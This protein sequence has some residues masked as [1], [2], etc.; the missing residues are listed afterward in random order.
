MLIKLQAEQVSLFWD[1]IREGLIRSYKIPKE[2]QQEFAIASLKQILVGDTQCWLGYELNE[3]NKLPKY[4]V[5]TQIVD[6]KYLGL[7]SLY[8]VAFYSLIT[9][10]KEMLAE[11]ASEIVPYAKSNN[12]QVVLADFNHDRVKEFLTELGFENYRSTAR[13]FL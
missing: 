7:R 8:I 12:C 4:F 11:F 2:Y 10:T 6:E 5:A 9:V 13:L 1:M 3:E